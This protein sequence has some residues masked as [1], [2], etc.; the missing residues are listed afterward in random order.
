ME[1][2][3]KKIILWRASFHKWHKDWLGCFLC[4]YKMRNQNIKVVN[5][6]FMNEEEA[7]EKAFKIWSEGKNWTDLSMLIEDIY[8]QYENKLS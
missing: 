6:K 7:K 8:N 2:V 5:K 3:V 1:L 4:E